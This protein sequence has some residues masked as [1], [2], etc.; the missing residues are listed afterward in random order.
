M[1][2]ILDGL[3]LIEGN[4]NKMSARHNGKKFVNILIADGHCE[5]INAGKNLPQTKQDMQGPD[6]WVLSNKYPYPKWR[7]EQQ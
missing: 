7:M 2:I 1:A 6:W 4:P 3:R 5:S